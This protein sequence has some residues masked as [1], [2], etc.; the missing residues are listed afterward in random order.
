M[1][2]CTNGSNYPVFQIA[3]GNGVPIGAGGSVGATLNV[4]GDQRQAYWI[5]RFN[6]AGFLDPS[7]DIPPIIAGGY[8]PA[9]PGVAESTAFTVTLRNT[10]AGSV[11][12]SSDVL[13]DAMMI[14]DDTV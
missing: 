7:F 13:I 12:P 6:A 11:T 14:N 4:A 5:T 2:Q 9:S 3:L 10:S 1:R 8:T